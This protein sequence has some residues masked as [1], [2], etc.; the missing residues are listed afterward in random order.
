MAMSQD[1]EQVARPSRYRSLRKPAVSTSAPPNTE[2][3]VSD[4]HDLDRQ[5][6]GAVANTISRSMSRYRRRATSVAAEMGNDTARTVNS[7]SNG[8]PPV[9]LIPLS[10][11]TA[12]PHA[13]AGGPADPAPESSAQRQ[14]SQS[15]ARRRTTSQTTDNCGKHSNITHDGNYDRAVMSGKNKQPGVLEQHDAFWEERT[16]LLEEQK[17]KDLERLEAELENSRK[18]KAQQ[19]KLR[20]PVVEKFVLLAKGNRSNK[21]ATPSTSP[22]TSTRTSAQGPS[23]EPVKSPPTHIEPGGKGSVPQTDAPTSAI[24][25]GDR[26]VAVRYQHQTLSLPVTPDT[27]PADIIALA[28]RKALRDLESKTPWD[29]ER[30]ETCMVVEQYRVLGL[31]R[32]LRRYEHIRD[33]MNSWDKDAQNQLAVILIGA[34]ANHEDH[35]VDLVTNDDT[36]LGYQL[37][38]YHSNRPGKWN[39]RWINLLENGQIVSA[40]KQNAK[41]TDKDTISL[42]H[43]S[44]YDIYTPT[45]SQA[46]RH[47]KPPKSFCF[48]IKSQHK[49]TLFLNTDNYVHYFSTD[50][51]QVAQEF[52]QK[53]R[54]WRS[55]YLANQRPE[56]REKQT[57]STTKP[58]A[59]SRQQT[60]S[61][62]C[63][64]ETADHMTSADGHRLRISVDEKPYAI[65]QF[66]PLLDMTRFEKRLSQ[67]GED[68]LPPQ[69][70]P[71]AKQIPEQSTGRHLL[72][73]K[74]LDHR[75]VQAPKR[76]TEDGFTGGLLGEVY[77]DRKQALAELEMKKKRPDDLAFTEGPSL[78]NS[79]RDQEEW[80]EKPNSPSWFPSALEHT[81]KQRISPQAT[82]SRPTTSG[83]T[84]KGR[85]FSFNAATRPPTR[86]P[87]RP[88]LSHLHPP[89]RSNT[90][91][92]QPSSQSCSDQQQRGGPKPLVDLTPKFREPPQWSKDKKGHGVKPPDGLGQLINFISDRNG[93]ESKPGHHAEQPPPRGT[94]QRPTT[95]SG[96]AASVGRTRSMSASSVAHGR[97]MPGDVPPVPCLP[98]Q[99]LGHESDGGGSG[100]GMR[101]P[102]GV[103]VARDG[104][105]VVDRREA[106]R[107]TAREH[108]KAQLIEREREQERQRREYR[109]RE[110]AYNAVPG[111]T[112][113]LKVV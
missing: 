57:K 26:N 42:C 77:D 14:L 44:D 39:K 22:S 51:P 71:P 27:A 61:N 35:D 68:I 15:G 36:S 9:P 29:S 48:A 113:T 56:V 25:A 92:S 72:Q 74:K 63:T 102:R 54:G 81:A 41:M 73:K 32:R 2:R 103:P 64:A 110:A 31:E 101:M 66:E 96:A 50:N 5:N 13:V 99:H 33:V 93:F 20:S 95:S 4:R 18:V 12:N 23:Q 109:E 34:S 19:N 30:P 67:F 40:K 28:S 59:R 43:L 8:A 7:D 83:D 94:F 65:G 111:R 85:R 10:L 97:P 105:R 86:E 47:L 53:T 98:S 11:K 80:P 55:R 62:N 89:P 69:R 91:R 3:A 87:S 38:I 49:T 58:E 16:R 106:V 84:A 60:S 79:Q 21:D 104:G 90:L 76:V 6:E 52:K 46:K 24:N 108:E 107:Q 100:G 88:P 75:P 37:Y 45:E 82:P 70:D 112:G 1:H 17:R 78:L